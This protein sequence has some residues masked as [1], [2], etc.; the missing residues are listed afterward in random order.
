MSVLPVTA[1]TFGP[2]YTDIAH[3]TGIAAGTGPSGV[4]AL[5]RTLPL[6]P[7]A[8]SRSYSSSYESVS[9]FAA[10]SLPPMTTPSTA[11]SAYKQAQDATT[12]QSLAPPSTGT[13]Q[14]DALAPEQAHPT[15]IPA[16][17]VNNESPE[18]GDNLDFTA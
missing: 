13:D 6:H 5:A 14:S 9:R 10:G 1:P 15:P 12:Q 18:G 8:G 17:R 4:T 16:H 7:Y 11:A 2:D 3:S